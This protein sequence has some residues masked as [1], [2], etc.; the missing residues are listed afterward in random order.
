MVCEELG[1]K[2]VLETMGIIQSII[3]AALN[4]HDVTHS[5]NSRL[6]ECMNTDINHSMVHTHTHT[7]AHTQLSHPAQYETSPATEHE[8]S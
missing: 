3:R 8:M 7:H 5:K 4:I 6:I 2:H 1:L